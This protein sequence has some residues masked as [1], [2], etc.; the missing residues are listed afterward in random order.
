MNYTTLETAE[1]VPFNLDGRKMFVDPRAEII[2]LTLKPGEVL[3]KH[4]NPF[5]VVIYIVDGEGVIETSGE[6]LSVKAS[7]CIPINA[8]AQRGLKNVGFGSL[9]ALVFKIF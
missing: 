6:K 3:E 8:G 5:D 9:K 4:T 2:H 1:K 7:H